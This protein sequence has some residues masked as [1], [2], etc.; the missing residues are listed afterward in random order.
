MGRGSYTDGALALDYFEQPLREALLDAFIEQLL[1]EDPPS[2]TAL[3]HVQS[4]E[5]E[6]F[7]GRCEQPLLVLYNYRDGID[8]APLVKRLAQSFIDALLTDESDEQLEGY[9][10]R[11]MLVAGAEEAEA[12]EL[13][14]I[15]DRHKAM[16]PVVHLRGTGASALCGFDPSVDPGRYRVHDTA[17]RGALQQPPR[18]W[19]RCDHCLD[20]GRGYPAALESPQFAVLSAEERRVIRDRAA[21][22][23]KHC[24]TSREKRPARSQ[25]KGAVLEVGHAVRVAAH[26]ALQEQTIERLLLMPDDERFRRWFAH[27]HCDPDC[28]EWH[29]YDYIR[30]AIQANYGNKIDNVPFPSVDALRSALSTMPRM[31][32]SDEELQQQKK[33]FLADLI[34]TTWPAS[35]PDIVREVQANSRMLHYWRER[36]PEALAGIK[37]KGDD[38]YY[39]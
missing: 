36:W 37:L 9:A 20:L 23:L 21:A 8:E 6:I 1:L 17:P 3:A 24:L 18:R 11:L 35:I 30:R 25:L 4:L 34:F 32:R 27:F 15:T 31:V 12:K 19:R 33:L 5:H 28:A 38:D 10:R 39:V 16:T 13:I 22:A 2:P 26:E 29:E 7:E 14:A